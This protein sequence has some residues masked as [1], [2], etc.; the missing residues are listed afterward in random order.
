MNDRSPANRC[1]AVVSRWRYAQILSEL[2]LICDLSWFVSSAASGMQ[3]RSIHENATRATRDPEA[4]PN[5]A[6]SIQQNSARHYHA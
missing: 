1:T 3:G 5:H 2:A 6:A 4:D